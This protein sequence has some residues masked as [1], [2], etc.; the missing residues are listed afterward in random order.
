M[1]EGALT[2]FI[3]YVTHIATLWARHGYW[4]PKIGHAQNI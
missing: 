4:R 1:P 3:V 2:S